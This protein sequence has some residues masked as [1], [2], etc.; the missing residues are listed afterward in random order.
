MRITLDSYNNMNNI[1]AMCFNANAIVDNLAYN[2][3]Y[4][5]YNNIA[6]VV[7]HHVAHIMPQWS[8]LFSEKL[9]E[10]SGRPIRK[11]ING[12][13]ED[14]KDL[15]DIF[16]VLLNTLM[17]LR[18]SVQGLIESA[19]MDG[20]DEVRIFAEEFL[21]IMSPYIK[22]AEEWVNASLVL[23]PGDLNIHIKDYTHFIDI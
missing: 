3:D 11:D 16:K 15:K 14:Y 9:L 4:Y 2:L 6:E 10:L 5:Y 23:S 17:D 13:E 1:I 18:R 21:M 7:H 22:Q 19:D 20:D 8:D 12:Y